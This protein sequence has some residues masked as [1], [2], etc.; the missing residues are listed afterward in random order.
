MKRLTYQGII[1]LKTQGFCDIHDITKSVQRVVEDSCIK[2][3]IVCVMS[4]GATA[5]ITTC[6]Y[7]SGLISDIK[8]FFEKFIPQEAKY[9]HNVRWG[10]GNGFSHVRA[11]LLGPSMSL[12]ISKGVLVLGTWQ[13]IIYID[14]DNRSRNR[15]LFVQIVGE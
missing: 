3:G 5:G 15:E 2:M 1:K 14:F 7:E 9:Q 11:S 8:D 6:E 10:D 4:P 13:Q 12:P